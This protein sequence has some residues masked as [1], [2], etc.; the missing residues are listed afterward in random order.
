MPSPKDFP[1]S[2]SFRAPKIMTM[3]RM[4]RM[5]S[6]GPTGPKKNIKTSSEGSRCCLHNSLQNYSSLAEKS[7]GL[8]DREAERKLS[9]IYFFIPKV[10]NTITKDKNKE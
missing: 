9:D 5:S 3:I 8:W 2:G 10:W 1:N 4:I 6:V 7:R